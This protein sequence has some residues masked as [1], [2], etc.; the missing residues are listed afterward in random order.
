MRRMNYNPFE[1]PFASGEVSKEEG[2]HFTLDKPLEEGTYLFEVVEKDIATNDIYNYTGVIK[3]D[4]SKQMASEFYGQAYNYGVFMSPLNGKN[5]L[6]VNLLNNYE[7]DTLTYSYTIY[8]Y[9]I[10]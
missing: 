6:R 3:I 4:H 1:K 2:L 7:I 10:A 8:I 5:I 9:K